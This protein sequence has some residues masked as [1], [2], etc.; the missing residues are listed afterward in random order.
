[1]RSYHSSSSRE[2]LTCGMQVRASLG[3]VATPFWYVLVNCILVESLTGPTGVMSD[4]AIVSSS[5]SDGD[6]GRCRMWAC[7]TWGICGAL[8]CLLA[9]PFEMGMAELVLQP[10]TCMFFQWSVHV[11]CALLHWMLPT[12]GDSVPSSGTAVKFACAI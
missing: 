1:M 2:Q 11:M 12:F 9:C 4:T 10:C 7:L 8:H 3:A 5:L 6:Y